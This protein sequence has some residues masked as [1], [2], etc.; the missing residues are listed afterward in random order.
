MDNN[1]ISF[2]TDNIN[3]NVANDNINNEIIEEEDTTALQQLMAPIQVCNRHPPISH[4]LDVQIMQKY[5][6]CPLL[7]RPPEKTNILLLEGVETF[8]RTGNNLI[9][10][11]H[12]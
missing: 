3:V 8:G 4:E 9:E 1:I 6:R 5:A 10:F 2:E 11:L 12:R 7:S